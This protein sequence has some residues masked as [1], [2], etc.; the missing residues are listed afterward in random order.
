MIRRIL[1]PN[2]KY[3]SLFKLV[4]AKG[5]I[6]K[7]SDS[8]VPKLSIAEFY[9]FREDLFRAICKHNEQTYIEIVNTRSVND[10]RSQFGMFWIIGVYED[11]Y[12]VKI[13]ISETI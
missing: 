2:E 12:G 1:K 9:S 8:V 11:T 7:Y 13:K 5:I 3:E 10:Y 6:S 4:N